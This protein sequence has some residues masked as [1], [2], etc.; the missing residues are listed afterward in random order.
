MLYLSNAFSIQMLSNNVN[1]SFKKISVVDARE[2]THEAIYI[3]NFQGAI[4][5][6]D[7]ANVVANELGIS[8]NLNNRISLKLKAKSDI[9]IVAQL[10]GGRL[11]EGTTIL[12]DGFKIEYWLVQDLD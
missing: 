2:I 5:H 8:L 12:P 3:E 7:T 4:G 10:T 6:A 9:L 1:L 11:P